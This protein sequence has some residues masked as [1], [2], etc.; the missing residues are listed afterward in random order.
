MLPSHCTRRSR[1]SINHR[2]IP[3]FFTIQVR[4]HFLDKHWEHLDSF[5]PASDVQFH[6]YLPRFPTQR[7]L[8]TMSSELSPNILRVHRKISRCSYCVRRASSPEFSKIAGILRM[9]EVVPLYNAEMFSRLL[10]LTV[11][12]LLT[13]RS[14][15]GR[16]GVTDISI[17]W[18]LLLFLAAVLL[19]L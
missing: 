8:Q 7:H 14:F 2:I 11:I 9:D 15:G 6:T 4:F 19:S 1:T 16:H 17:S 5:Y 10:E 12:S 13:D 18:P 3:Y